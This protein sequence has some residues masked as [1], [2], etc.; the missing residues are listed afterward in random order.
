MGAGGLRTRV[1]VI[2]LLRCTILEPA[3][4]MSS[5]SG[6]SGCS[7]LEAG[8]VGGWRGDISEYG[9]VIPSCDERGC[10]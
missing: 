10:G 7:S 6:D 5:K 1:P 8:I 2:P 3:N 4:M 9:R